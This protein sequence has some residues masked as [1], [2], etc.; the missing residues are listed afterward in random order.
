MTSSASPDPSAFYL[1]QLSRQTSNCIV[2][3]PGVT[4]TDYPIQ[5]ESCNAGGYY[6][7]WQIISDGAGRYFLYNRGIGGRSQRLDF[8]QPPGYPLILIMGPSNDTYNNQRW[9][10]NVCS[11]AIEHL[12]FSSNGTR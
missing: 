9:T 11:P 8:V 4:N 3:I 10:L 2:A 5:V 7:Q 12:I 6:A 1:I